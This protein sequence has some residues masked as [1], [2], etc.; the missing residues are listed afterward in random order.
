ML[1]CVF[2]CVSFLRVQLVLL[3]NFKGEETYPL[4][5]SGDM[6]DTGT[7]WQLSPRSCADWGSQGHMIKAVNTVELSLADGA[8]EVISDLMMPLS[9]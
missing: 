5:T 7:R 6:I 8:T 1:G 3:R 2:M 4:V 9:I